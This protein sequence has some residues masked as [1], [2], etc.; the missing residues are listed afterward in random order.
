MALKPADQTTH[1]QLTT[2]WNRTQAKQDVKPY[3]ERT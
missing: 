2:S 1:K 3:I